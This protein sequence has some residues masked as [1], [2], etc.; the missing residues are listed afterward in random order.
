M[1]IRLPMKDHEAARRSLA[2]IIRKYY[3]NELETPKFRGLVYGFATLLQYF[4]LDLDVETGAKLDEVL[5]AIEER[6]DTR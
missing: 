1:G 6:I 5:D 3:C 2:R 4:R